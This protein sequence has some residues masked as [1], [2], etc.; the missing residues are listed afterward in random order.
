MSNK[1][2]RLTVVS[3][4][5]G[6]GKTTTLVRKYLSLLKDGIS[7]RSI[8]AITFTRKA[9]AELV[10]A[11]SMCLRA[12]QGRPVPDKF[13]QEY[14][15]CYTDC[16]PTD[17]RTIQDALN[18]LPNAPA[19][20]VDS[21]VLNLLSE[22]AL[23][24]RLPVGDD[25]DP[26]WLDFPIGSGGVSEVFE[27]AIREVIDPKDGKVPPEAS[28]LLKHMGIKE[29][30][31]RVSETISDLSAMIDTGATPLT[32][33]EL[34]DMVLD[35]TAEIFKTAVKDSPEILT[36]DTKDTKPFFKPVEAWRASNYAGTAPLDLLAWCANATA[37]NPEKLTKKATP[38]RYALMQEE[39]DFGIATVGLD[40]AVLTFKGGL[41]A[42]DLSECDRIRNDLIVLSLKARAHALRMAAASGSLDHDLL[43]EA[44]IDLCTRKGR[45]ERLKKR[46]QALLVDEV[47]DS[48][49]RQ[50]ELYRALENLP[51]D[52]GHGDDNQPL[53]TFFVG[54]SRQSIYLFRGAEPAELGELVKRAEST[55]G[56]LDNLDKN[57]RST[58]A[59]VE[60]QK[61][62]F[63]RIL[64]S[65]G[66]KPGLAG[67]D[68]FDHVTSN[69]K[70]KVHELPESAPFH[71][72]I[73]TVT[74]DKPEVGQED[75]HTSEF[76]DA[77]IDVFAER[78]CH[79]WGK[80]GEDRP[81][82]TA[83]VL[84]TSWSKA[85]VARD[86]LRAILRAASAGDAFLDGSRE[87]TE[88]QVAM[89]VRTIVKA[90]WDHTDD[91]SWAGLWRHPMIGISDA[92]L[93]AFQMGRG[94]QN[95]G[96]PIRGLARA[97]ASDP[98]SPEVFPEA[99]I[100]AFNR[101]S[102][103][104][105]RATRE[106]GRMPT[107]DVVE[108]LASNLQWRS[109]LLNGPGGEDSVAQL[110]VI[111]D[112]IRQTEADV[113]D[114]DKVVSMLEQGEADET[115]RVELYRGARS[116]SCTTI[117][118]AK[119]LKYDHV[120]IYAI[121]TSPSGA[122]DES[123]R[124]ASVVYNGKSK[125]LVGVKID[126]NRALKPTAD[127]IFRLVDRIN[128]IRRDQERLRLAYVAV[129]RAVRSVTF[130]VGAGDNGIHD[131]LSE[132]WLAEPEIPGVTRVSRPA[133]KE[134]DPSIAA[135][136]VAQREF[137]VSPLE[138]AGWKSVSPSRAAEAWDGAGEDASKKLAA[139][140][141]ARC[142]FRAGGDRCDPPPVDGETPEH[143]VTSDA[144]GTM[145]HAWMEKGGLKAGANQAAAE[146]FL[147]E[148][149]GLADNV[150]LAKWLVK[151]VARL[152]ETQS[153][154]MRTLR[155]NEV[156]LHFEM[157]F[158]GVDEPFDGEKWFHAGRM[159]LLVEFPARKAFWVIDFKA[160][161]K[162]PTSTD[163]L[164]PGASL[165][166]YGPQLEAY[167]RSLTSA[168]HKIEKVALL[169]MRTGA[170]VAW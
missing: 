135:H 12:S 82:D 41:D 102:P 170:W 143:K 64:E 23:E 163:D 96:K 48:S 89:D 93:A 22:F 67:I 77:A 71:E 36:I 156:R 38:L 49:P 10:E 110:E 158:A 8:I 132:R 148:T 4:A 32:G 125:T 61:A 65:C 95:S 39:I 26:A 142:E 104:L 6:T 81:D 121:G 122:N 66:D 11:V 154:L 80:D 100:K 18:E 106:I 165:A 99:D 74:L 166:E 29:L 169:F 147:R 78:I 124:R 21:F 152:E 79:A 53:Q 7:P 57:Y 42:E 24:A 149:Y 145:V 68:G 34:V 113:V 144:W 140:I 50:F 44:A 19:G 17:E 136:V 69:E 119:G 16:V 37:G 43:T 84:T 127:P 116:V 30:I 141:A 94:I 25:G 115:P 45:S 2:N 72:P 108:H 133:P 55:P 157:P 98:L 159:D 146:V 137:P 20:T 31:T 164:I 105:V 13:R 35:R 167:R 15:D 27:A 62:L 103:F 168:G 56:A 46:F 162:S 52:P 91:I 120:M 87:L 51:V 160:G 14:E 138:P 75:W 107:A 130:A 5:A 126:P 128:E 129:T 134:I 3:A 59:M 73:V 101:A 86:R 54:D 40:E 60:A 97:L 131:S 109:I 118:Q 161:Q 88:G 9:A 114:P 155:S 28:S 76:H 139:D 1:N 123:W 111:L 63:N 47:Q 33:I 92:G 153:D 83:A 150:A 151:L 70:K 90:L 58:P 112:W 117:H 85:I